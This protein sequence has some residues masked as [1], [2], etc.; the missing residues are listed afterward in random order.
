[1]AYFQERSRQLLLF[2]VYIIPT[3]PIIIIIFQL[4]ILVSITS[5]SFFSSITSSNSENRFLCYFFR[6]YLLINLLLL[7]PFKHETS[8]FYLF[9]FFFKNRFLITIKI[10]IFLAICHIFLKNHPPNLISRFWFRDWIYLAIRR[11]SLHLF[12]YTFVFSLISSLIRS[13][14]GSAQG[15]ANRTESLGE[16]L[17]MLSRRRPVR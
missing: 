9:N 12:C 10:F 16:Q 13:A 17:C 4:C 5:L 8:T 1:M 15:H 11:T 7:F 2:Y 3:L 14:R 6:F